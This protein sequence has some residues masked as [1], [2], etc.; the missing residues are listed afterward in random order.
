[1]AK[2]PAE[3]P[4]TFHGCCCIT[5]TGA[6]SIPRCARRTSGIWQTF[7]WAQVAAE[8]KKLAAGLHVQGFRAAT[9]WRS[10]ARTGHGCTSR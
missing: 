4:D 8:V 2:A 1:M 6:T 5:R 9:T 7:T 3:L 10:S